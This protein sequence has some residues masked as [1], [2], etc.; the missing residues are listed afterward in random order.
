MNTIGNPKISN[1]EDGLEYYAAKEA[2]CDVIVTEDTGDFW[3]SEINVMDCEGFISHLNYPHP[4]KQSN[5]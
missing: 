5:K 2:D 1:F 3:F 4:N